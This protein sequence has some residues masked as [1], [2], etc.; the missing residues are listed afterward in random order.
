[1]RFVAQAREFLKGVQDIQGI[2]GQR[3]IN[4]MLSET[5]LETTDNGITIYATDLTVSVQELVSADVGR[6][7]SIVVQAKKIFE[8]ARQLPEEEVT[9]E[10][11]D[12]NWL[13]LCSGHATFKIVGLPPEEFPPMPEYDPS[14]LSEIN[15]ASLRSALGKIIS[16]MCENDAR[17]YL[18]GGLIEFGAEEGTIFVSTDSHRLSYK[19]ADIGYRHRGAKPVQL[20]LPKKSIEEIMRLFSDEE[21]VQLGLDKRRLL[22]KS[23]RLTFL[24]TLIDTDYPDYR[25][26]IPK[27]CNFK[28]K[29]SRQD[30]DSVLK[31]VSVCSDPRTH[32]VRFFFKEGALTLVGEDAEIGEAV[33][34]IE[35]EYEGEGLT[36]L[37]QK[38]KQEKEASRLSNDEA[39]IEQNHED[40]LE[41]DYNA[42]FFEEAL[43]I[44]ES[45]KVVFELTEPTSGCVLKPD[46][47]APTQLCIIMPMGR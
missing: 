25:A 11:L 20:I 42:S 29:V 39:P 36:K 46:E 27:S 8:I 44:I 35:A 37:I 21:A 7:G 32:R 33:D 18:N 4:P 47:D 43:K 28:A 23:D 40:R 41:V 22:F 19:L 34:E 26:V 17:R 14:C 30:L 24:S 15:F 2:A 38:Q 3:S 13:K 1:M 9:V 16:S 5:L 6:A 45:D 31:R 12:G 10:T